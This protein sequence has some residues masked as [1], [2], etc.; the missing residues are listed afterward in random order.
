MEITD[1]ILSRF[2]TRAFLDKPVEK[3]VIEEILR[4]ASHAPSAVN[5]QPWHVAVLTGKTKEALSKLILDARAKDEP[6]R[7]DYDYYPTE[8]F[9]PYKSRRKECGHALYG[10]LGI[11]IEDKDK[12][13]VQWNRNYTFF[14]APTG[15]LFLI[16]A[17]LAKGSWMDCAF[18]IQNVMLTAEQF[19]LST[20]P[21]ASMAEYPDLVRKLLNKPDTMHV[22]CG[23]ALGYEDKN[24]VVNQYRT[25]RVPVSDFTEWFD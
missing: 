2:S 4:V 1:A 12:R 18:F 10:A 9:E 8:W 7:P 16:D 21:Q 19:G 14:G 23:M 24:A 5:T 20:C 25:S 3:S 6:Q 22:M 11:G 17:R 13:L 15:L